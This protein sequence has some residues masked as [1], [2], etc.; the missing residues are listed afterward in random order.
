MRATAISYPVNMVLKYFFS[1]VS[2]KLT[3][4]CDIFPHV[5]H[6]LFLTTPPHSPTFQSLIIPLG[7]SLSLRPFDFQVAHLSLTT[8]LSACHFPWDS[9]N[10]GHTVPGRLLAFPV[11]GTA[12][13]ICQDHPN[14]S[15]LTCRFS[16]QFL[17]MLS[18]PLILQIWSWLLL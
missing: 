10:N 7:P 11:L 2:F 17:C 3:F 1:K 12:G 8:L 16:W 13:F 15:S 14:L 5:F 6:R 18:H 9:K 4:P